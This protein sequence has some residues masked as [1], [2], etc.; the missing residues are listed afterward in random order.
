[1]CFGIGWRDL[2]QH[3]HLGR[4]YGL[5]S[6]FVVDASGVS[7]GSHSAGPSGLGLKLT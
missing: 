2:I 5:R 3:A 7:T 6:W 1:M 4:R